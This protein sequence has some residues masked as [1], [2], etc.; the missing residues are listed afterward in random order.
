MPQGDRPV[1]PVALF[2]ALDRSSPTPLHRQL[3][4]HLRREILAGRLP[5]GQRLPPTRSFADQLGVSRNTVVSAF[6][7]LLAEGYVEGRVGSGTYVAASIPDDVLEVASTR[8]APQAGGRVRGLSKRGCRLAGL[9]L[10]TGVRDALPFRTAVPDLVHLPLS[11][12]A[13]IA[14]RLL[15]RPPTDL[16][17]Y[18]DA[19]GYEP[20]RRALAAHVAATRGV[21]CS[22][23]QVLIVSGSQQGLALIANVLLDPGD[24][25]WI[26]DP[27]YVGSRATLTTAGIEPLPVPVDDEGLDVDWARGHHPEAR[28]TYVTPSHQ[29]PTGVI[30]SLAR[31][32]R[33]LD[34]AQRTDAWIVEDDY[35]GEYRYGGM[36]L[37][38]L[39][40]LDRGQRVL[41]LGTLSKVLFPSLRLGYLVVP[42]DLVDAFCAA[43][44]LADRHPPSLDQA[45]LA[46]FI[47]EGHLGRHIRR[48]R[49]LYR[50]RQEALLSAL[51]QHLDGLLE[52]SVTDTGMHLVAW[53]PPEVDDRA[54]T[55][56]AAARGLVAPAISAYSLAHAPRGGLVL[57]FAAFDGSQI[58]AGTRRLAMALEHFR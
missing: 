34:W 10:D 2:F 3:Y 27:G 56:A 26:E 45:I 25:A 17:T 22:P 37:E 49:A 30:M 12:W 18:G 21:V 23:D 42:R 24:S 5:S 54:A 31:R 47:D 41:Y 44:V 14:R 55:A 4:D 35:D 40:G 19:R 57:G 11:A 39:Q 7:Q 43:K 29:F 50:A 52:A 53:L 20:L 51:G 28:L 58:E 15:R 1:E 9:S 8:R 32:L 36:P 46:D 33:L 38:S 13:K 48:M 16:L 6:D